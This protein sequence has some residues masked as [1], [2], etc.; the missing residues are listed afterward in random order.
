MLIL[1]SSKTCFFYRIVIFLLFQGVVFSS[2][3]TP[4][5]F[6][7]KTDGEYIGDFISYKLEESGYSE[8]LPKRLLKSEFEQSFSEVLNFG[9]TNNIYWIRFQVENQSLCK[10]LF[11][12]CG[13][14][15]YYVFD[16]YQVEGNSVKLLGEYGVTGKYDEHKGEL[17]TSISFPIEVEKGGIIDLLIKVKSNLGIALP[18]KIN[19]QKNYLKIHAMENI[20]GGI[21]FGAIITMLLYNFFL[22]L[23]V[24]DRNYI[25]YVGY[26]AFLLL[27]LASFKGYAPK[28]LWSEN[29]WLRENA[30][31]IFCCF[32][33]ISGIQFGYVFLEIKKRFFKSVVVL[34]G[35]QIAVLINLVVYF[36]YS[37]HVAFNVFYLMTIF[38]MFLMSFLAVLVYR[39]GHFASKYYIAGQC[40]FF[41]SIFFT[42]LRIYDFIPHNFLTTHLS[43]MGTMF[44][45]TIFSFALA[46][47]INSMKKEKEITQLQMIE[48]ERKYHE[49]LENQNRFLGE[50]VKKQMLELEIANK[51][52]KRQTLSAQIN[53]HFIF[54][55]L[56]SIQSYLLQQQYDLA[57]N[58]LSKFSR[59][60]RF[61]LESSFKKFVVLRDEIDAIKTYLNIEKMR[62]DNRFD[63]K[64]HISDDID[65]NHF[66]I[67]SL[68]IL[69]FLENAVWHGVLNREGKGLIVIKILKS[70]NI[71]DV[72]IIDDGV[73]IEYA[74][75][76]RNH[77]SGNSVGIHIT[78]Q[79]I[80][81]LNEIYD[82]DYK[83]TITDLGKASNEVVFGT[84][85]NF[86][87]PF[88][89][90]WPDYQ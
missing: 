73:G 80:K 60:I 24:R 52:L 28:Y 67:P 10:E 83:F 66:E 41:L 5:V 21:Y 69:P 38:M 75:K 15:S 58:Y 47:R 61:Y 33:V 70:D 6:N 39:K 26:I 4:F 87:I 63:Y 16:V 46:S 65:I 77:T 49:A 29:S 12:E 45:V 36:L 3:S 79:K 25:Y 62:T 89:E 51:E 72:S 81:L 40:V 11:F 34:R 20:F 44:D 7:D 19:S 43:E 32:S 53:P 37:K 71:L 22:Y 56:N 14:S 74:K 68:V 85:V 9:V 54:N 31:F 78:E 18:I 8:K 48:S 13:L 35:L 57:E 59:L 23:Q 17:A 55:V 84:E 76:N 2:I 88:Q 50:E 86:T 30:T 42:I 82:S 64:I 27:Y 1:R 90:N